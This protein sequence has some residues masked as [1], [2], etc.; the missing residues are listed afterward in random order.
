MQAVPSQYFAVLA[1]LVEDS[2]CD[3]DLLLHDSGLN[4]AEI[5]IPDRWIDHRIFETAVL[6]A[7]R[8]TGNPALGL[9]FG[10]SLNLSRHTAL[11]YAAM[12]SETLEQALSLLLRYYRLVAFNLELDFSTE[13]DYCFFTVEDDRERWFHQSFSY[14][15][16]FAAFNSSMRYLMQTQDLR[17]R[18][19]IAAPEPDYS[20][21]FYELLGPDVRFSQARFRMGCV[22]DLLST[23]LAGANPGLAKIYATQCEELLLQM[24]LDAS[25]AEKVRVLLDSCEGVYPNH[26]DVAGMLAMSSRT[27]RRKLELEQTSFQQLMDQ[28]RSKQAINCLR[29]TRLP[30]SSIA[31]RVGFNDASNFRRAFRRWTGKSPLQFRQQ[32]GG[33]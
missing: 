4:A 26:G 28:V 9:A 29:Q 15:C 31:Y 22:R 10:Q 5:R 8:L 3:S 21:R 24:K 12:N 25:V 11:G 7:Y 6:R 13:Q 30:L 14:E 19:D 2:G 23:S 32:H 1:A 33:Q 17:L 16:L 18:F 27:L 20:E